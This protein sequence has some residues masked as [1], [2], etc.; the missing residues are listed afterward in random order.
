MKPLRITF[1]AGARPNF[2]KV[3]PLI[4]ASKACSDVDATLVHTGQHYDEHMSAQFFRD[5]DLPHP[6]VHL[7]VGSATSRRAD[8]PC[9][10]RLRQN[11]R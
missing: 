1:I 4:H 9:H 10:D 8:R 6:D 5:L 11:A 3:A 2:M 7:E